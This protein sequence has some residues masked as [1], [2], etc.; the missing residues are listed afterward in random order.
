M[1]LAIAHREDN[2]VVVDCVLEKKAPFHPD[3]TVGEFT[4]TLKQYKCAVVTGD[5]YGGAWPK[6]RFAAYGIRYE[7][8]EMNRSELYLALLPS[9]ELWQGRLARQP[10]AREPAL[11]PRASHCPKWQG[12]RG[13]RAGPT[14]RRRKCGCWCLRACRLGRHEREHFSRDR[15]SLWRRNGRPRPERAHRAAARL[16]T[17]RINSLQH[18]EITIWQRQPTSTLCRIWA[19]RRARDSRASGACGPNAHTRGPIVAAPGG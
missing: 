10:T 13:S 2:R 12:Q 1:T 8:A 14:R 5:R 9:L 18:V 16:R 17:R 15:R 19:A 4:G 11:R 6:E 7:P 3:Q